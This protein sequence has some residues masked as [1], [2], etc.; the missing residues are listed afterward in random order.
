MQHEEVLQSCEMLACLFQI[1]PKQLRSTASSE[2]DDFVSSMCS[3]CSLWLQVEVIG[4]ILGKAS[5]FFY[6]WVELF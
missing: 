3:C 4:I 1:L 6:A 2:I 5:N